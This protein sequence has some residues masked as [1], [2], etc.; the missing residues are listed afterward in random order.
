MIGRRMRSIA[1]GPTL[2][3]QDLVSD[4][5]VSCTWINALGKHKTA[6][7]GLSDLE[8][9]DPP[10]ASARSQDPHLNLGAPVL[11]VALLQMLTFGAERLNALVHTPPWFRH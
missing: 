2:V 9:L 3:V 11:L 10:A 7:F 4:E 1:G 6:N 5:V 8:D